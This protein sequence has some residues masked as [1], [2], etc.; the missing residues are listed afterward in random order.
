MDNP[1]ESYKII[2]AG[3][4][5]VCKT[6]LLMK[7]LDDKSKDKVTA[8]IALDIKMKNVVCQGQNIKLQIWDTAGQERYRAVRSTYYRKASGIILMYDITSH[9]SFEDLEYWIKEIYAEISRKTPIILIGNKTDLHLERKV[10]Q[11]E[12]FLVAHNY[13]FPY[14]ETMVEDDKMI[15]TA[16][17]V[18]TSLIIKPQLTD[19]TK[20][21]RSKRD[22]DNIS[23]YSNITINTNNSDVNNKPNKTKNGFFSCFF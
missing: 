21:N 4:S 12:A 10:T 18:L 23:I 11:D 17:K 19:V 15:D 8:T 22:E 9:E 1:E 2:L 7:Y 6:S 20:I 5:G 13:H 14:F 3:C 16:F